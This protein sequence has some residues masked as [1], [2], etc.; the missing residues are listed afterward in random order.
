MSQ[1]NLETYQRGVAAIN[2]REF[3]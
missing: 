3:S 1:E 2:G